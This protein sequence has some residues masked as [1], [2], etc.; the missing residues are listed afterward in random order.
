LADLTFVLVLL[1]F[2][3]P[4]LP[5]MP[6]VLASFSGAFYSLIFAFSATSSAAKGGVIYT[7]FSLWLP[8]L[9]SLVGLLW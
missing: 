3:P 9:L 5:L 1:G 2:S 7:Y 4:W 6:F 8:L